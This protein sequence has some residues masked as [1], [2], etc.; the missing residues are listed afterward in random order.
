MA[1][2]TYADV[3]EQEVKYKALAD[4]SLPLSHL[5]KQNYDHACGIIR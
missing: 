4:L 5:D 2:L 3:I 1:K